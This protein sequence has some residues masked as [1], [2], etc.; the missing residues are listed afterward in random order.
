MLWFRM[1][2]TLWTG[3]LVIV[4]WNVPLVRSG[5]NCVHFGGIINRRSLGDWIRLQ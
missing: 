5:V 3:V 4:G 2:I 1:V